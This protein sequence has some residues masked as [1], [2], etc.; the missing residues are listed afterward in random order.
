MAERLQ[1]LTRWLH[2]AGGL[3]D[4]EID[5]VSGDASFRR[6]FRV[7]HAKGTC[8]AMD[9]PPDK[10][11]SH[12]FVHVAALFG[13]LGLNVPRV[14][15]AD[16][17]QG[18]LLLTDLGDRLYLSEL[19]ADT[20]DRL[21]GDALDALATLQ[22]CGPGADTLPPYDA[23][24][25]REE[26]ERFRE[27][28]LTRHLGLNLEA[29]QH[30]VLD[31]AFELLTASALEQPRVCVHRD[32]HSRNLLV[33]EDNPG[34]LD[35]Q[36]AVHGPVTYDLVSL[37]RDCYIAWPTERVYEWA[38]GYRERAVQSGILGDEDAERFLRWFDL[39]GIQRHLKATGIFARL[40]IR[41]AKP[42]YL[43]DV[44]RTLG[45]VLEVSARYPELAEFKALLE[46]LVGPRLSVANA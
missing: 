36:D 23:P 25:L 6:Y 8:I 1:A 15:L 19:N 38:L 41:D 43:N 26:M 27:W 18:F 24:L 4:F 12:P 44:P 46:D 9:A 42:A 29:H 10:E 45:Y 21:Y 28:Y 33:A 5:Q 37:L 11:D 16:L 13:E 22:A 3:G 14:L 17:S 34:I 31:T 30:A 20:V 40:N 35:F 39:M 7:R 32:Y 2:E